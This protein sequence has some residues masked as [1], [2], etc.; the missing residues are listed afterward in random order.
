MNIV[1]KF[2]LKNGLP[3]KEDSTDEYSVKVMR[4]IIYLEDMC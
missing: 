4:I 3:Y 2:V 1:G